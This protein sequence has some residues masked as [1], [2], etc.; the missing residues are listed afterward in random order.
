MFLFDYAFIIIYDFSEKLYKDPIFKLAYTSYTILGLLIIVSLLP[1]YLIIDFSLNL[2]I[3]KII[4]L[5]ISIPPIYLMDQKIVKKYNTSKINEL[6]LLKNKNE[7]VLNFNHWILV[8]F[9]LLK[10]CSNWLWK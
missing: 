7:L 8:I 1:V 6:H 3:N 5:F 4:F 10:V 2:N 9:I